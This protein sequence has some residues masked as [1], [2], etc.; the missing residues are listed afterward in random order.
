MTTPPTP[1]R[2]PVVTA[3]PSRS[4][5]DVTAVVVVG[6]TNDGPPNV[7][8]DCEADASGPTRWETIDSAVSMRPCNT[9][10]STLVVVADVRK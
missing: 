9:V 10:G 2:K 6:R 3:L 1:M 7:M 5:A 8:V 4:V